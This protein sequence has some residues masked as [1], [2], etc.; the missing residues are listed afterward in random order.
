MGDFFFRLYTHIQQRK[1]FAISV[2]LVI[3]GLLI[4]LGTT[5]RFDEDISKLIP[6]NSENEQLQKV[7]KTAQFAD[8]IIIHLKKEAD[9]DTEDLTDYATR[10]L[11]LLSVSSNPYIKNIQGKIEEETIFET[12]D[13]VY[14]NLPLFLNAGDYS[15]ISNKLQTDSLKALMASNYKTV[16]SPSGILAKK[17]IVKDPLGISII[18]LKHL[19]KLGLSDA[20]TLRDGFLVNKDEQDLL[21]FISPTFPSN[22]TTEN[23]VFAEQL[24]HIQATLNQEFNN[25]VTCSYFGGPLIAVANAHQIK[26]DIQ[27]TVT[28]AMVLLMSVFIVFY[29]K[30]TIPIILFVPTLLGGILA[31]AVLSLIRTEISAIS[32]GIGAVLMGVTLDYSL[33][34]LTHIRNGET[35]KELFY[36]VSK[37]I[38]MSSLTTSLAFLCL[39]FVDSQA[40]QDLGIFAAISV[41]GASVFALVFIPQAYKGIKVE[42]VNKTV[43][44]H[45]AT[46]SYHK[47]KMMVAGV[48]ILL[49]ISAFTYHNV[50]FNKDI[51]NLNYQPDD[52]KSA[53]QELDNLINISSKS[54]YAVTFGSDEQTVLQ[55]NDAI[56]QKL[57][58]LEKH[59]TILGF[60]SVAALV[61]SK[62]QQNQALDKWQQFWS[63]PAQS[64]TILDLREIGSQFGFKASSFNDFESLLEKN[65]QPL[66]VDDYRQLNILPVDDFISQ[67]S[68]WLT[69]T[70]VITVEEAQIDSV[71]K[72][73]AS[74]PNTLIIDRQA[75]NETLL[76][77][78]K[79][80]FNTVLIFCFLAV[81]ML[82]FLFYRNI[83]L[84]L[85]T[86]LPILVTWFI[87]LGIM[88]LFNLEFNIFNIIISTFIFGLGVDYSIFMTNGMRSGLSSM[89]T[90]KTSIIL[91][92]LTTV[93]GVGVL[94]FAKHPALHSLAKI[95]MIGILASMFISF[96]LQPILYQFFIGKNQPSK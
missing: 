92:V 18:A 58:D 5:I 73:F 11:E 41:M 16:I 13:F 89:E 63:S 33:H 84:T 21:V 15:T 87:T 71:K 45:L 75:L 64:N 69:I 37:P 79:N 60:N 12:M 19:Q 31:L 29:R 82:L 14:D 34:I 61:S 25:K 9:G 67:D 26:D 77:N 88:G 39:L 40:L 10:F 53:E 51:S 54:I 95:S 48:I 72:A 65:F 23:A 86:V 90:H 81:L 27:I 83:K 8:K 59:Q 80:D 47:N 76:G 22:N 38:L 62:Q 36:S 52:L 93:L 3:F 17:T 7:L 57:Q 43:F 6:Q 28:I 70:S 91:S 30:L 96:I 42:R 56:Y 66:T 35:T 74:I 2:S 1:L 46:Y 68:D 78:V 44:D 94:I 55:S 4:W 24:Y 85:V 20:F 50:T 49:I 32:L